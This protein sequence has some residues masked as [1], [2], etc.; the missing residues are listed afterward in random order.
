MPYGFLDLN[1][2]KWC[3]LKKAS[4]VIYLHFALKRRA[5]VEEIHEKQGQVKDWLQH[6]GIGDQTAVVNDNDEPDDG[7]FPVHN[8]DGV[9]KRSIPTRA[10]LS[11]IRPS[12]GRSTISEQAKVAMQN[13][14]NHFLGNIDIVNSREVCQF[15]EVSKLSFS[16]QYGPKLKEDYVM[17][18]HLNHI[19]R[20]G[21]DRGCFMCCCR[22]N[23]QKV[24]A[25]LKPGILALLEDPFGTKLLDIIVFDVLPPSDGDKKEQVLLAEEIKERN[26]LRYAFKGNC[27][28]SPT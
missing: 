22:N 12:I 9:K 25:V 10:A 23:W 26:P 3:L 24:W 15:L 18:H 19:Q 8:E 11:I 6:I 7:A 13:Y 4:Q 28:S 14:L 21:V 20:D 5:I 27:P 2:F 1:K 17:V 16:P